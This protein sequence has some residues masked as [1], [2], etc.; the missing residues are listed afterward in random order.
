MKEENSYFGG[1]FDI[2]EIA[3]W[4]VR[5]AFCKTILPVSFV[6]GQS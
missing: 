3:T 5:G 1:N 4:S 2:D 6:L